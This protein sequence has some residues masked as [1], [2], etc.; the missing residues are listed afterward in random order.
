MTNA[1]SLGNTRL[2]MLAAPRALTTRAEFVADIRREWTNALESTVQVGRRLNEAKAALPHGEYEAMIESELPFGPATAR[3]LREVAAF[4]DAGTVPLDQLPEAYSTLY[5]IATLPDEVRAEAVAQGVI[6]PDVT[7]AE[8]EAFKEAKAP[9]RAVPLPTPT[10]I[11]VEPEAVSA[12]VVAAPAS[13]LSAALGLRWHLDP[14][15]PGAITV[16][17]DGQRRV[18]FVVVAHDPAAAALVRHVLTMHNATVA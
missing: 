1:R 10:V 3:K 16:E 4:V 5:A 9:P 15:D 14:S 8:V 17:L 18:L 11:D 7:R 13:R 2:S 6:R 12:P